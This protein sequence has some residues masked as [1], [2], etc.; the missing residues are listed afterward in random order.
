MLA[1]DKQLLWNIQRGVK[2]N[3]SVHAVLH[4]PLKTSAVLPCLLRFHRNRHGGTCVCV[5]NFV[6]RLDRPAQ[7]V[8]FDPH[9]LPATSY[10]VKTSALMAERTS[11]CNVSWLVNNFYDCYFWKLVVRIIFTV[12]E[13]P[14]LSRRM[15]KYVPDG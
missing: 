7:A 1:Q 10:M 4:T 2:G 12:E 6:E 13:L 5:F 3:L 9:R 8:L 11:R 14:W 15:T